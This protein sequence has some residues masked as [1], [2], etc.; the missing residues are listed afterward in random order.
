MQQVT[1]QGLPEAAQNTPSFIVGAPPYR[2]GPVW[3][4]PYQRRRPAPKPQPF[5]AIELAV[6]LGITAV[7]DIASWHDGLAG[8]GFGLA[9]FFVVVPI[10][11]AFVARSRAVVPR[12]PR[13]LAIAAALGVVAVRCAYAPTVF[14]I[15][16]GM[17]LIG[18][19][20]LAL[21]RRSLSVPDV[22][23]SALASG[24]MAFT[25]IGAAW[26]GVTKLA[27]RTRVGKMNV[28]PIAIPAGLLLAFAGVFAL[29]NPVVADGLSAGWRAVARLIALPSPL[30]VFVW[31]STLAAATVALRPSI[32]VAKG[33]EVAKTEGEASPTALLVARNAL[34][35]LNVMFVAYLALDA[36]YLLLGAAPAGMT[37]QEYAHQG[38]FWLTV[39]LLMLT[40]VIGVMFK[41]PLA[42]DVLAAKTRKLAYAWMAQGLILGVG[43]Y[44]RIAI[45]I[46]HS[47]LSNLRIVGILGTTLVLSGVVL[48]ALKLRDGKTFTWLLRR[49]LDAFAVTMV[50][51]L[52]TPTHLLGAAVNVERVNHGEYRPLLHAFAQSQHAESAPSLLPLLNHGDIRVRQGVGALLAEERDA[53]RV[54]VRSQESWKSRD[55][56]SRHALAQLE[57][58]DIDGAVGKASYDDAKRVLLEI[59]HVANEDRSLE[60]ILAIP[61]AHDS[62]RYNQ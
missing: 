42:H 49:Q 24:G 22:F 47:G 34:V 2:S 46:A 1:S 53:L 5:R 21:K 41:G 13:V 12:T 17:G 4:P 27:A 30:R 14:N 3:S 18:A 7:V 25:R 48:V 44:R 10:A 16:A 9:L 26:T 31:I 15:L 8:G 6:A 40:A 23:L 57:A 36:R 28:L 35:G 59:T 62:S 19:F 55:L 61:A 52:V 29:A 50:I 11:M 33:T 51:Y 20:A 43:T 38:A 37:T 60:E 45:H 39:A 32:W 58:A 54:E 56:A